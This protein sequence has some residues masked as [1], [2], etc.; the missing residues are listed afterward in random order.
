M[1]DIVGKALDQPVYNLLGGPV[2]PRIKLYAN[3]WSDGAETPDEYAAAALM[4]VRERGF[5]A[6]KFDPFP[7]RWRLYPGREE[8][9]DAASVVGAVREAVGPKVELLIEAHRRLAPMNAIRVAKMLEPFN[10]YWFEEPC[11]AENIQAL[12]E[13]KDSTTIPVVTGEALYTRAAF[14]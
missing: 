3:G 11:P 14:R 10:P 2:R 8:L 13:V 1:W 7:G 9:E 5:S 12:R 6:L 4:T